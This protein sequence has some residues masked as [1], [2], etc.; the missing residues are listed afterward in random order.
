MTAGDPSSEDA[1]VKVAVRVRPVSKRETDLSTKCVVQMET[2]QT[3]LFH[4]AEEKHPKT[5]AFDH[6]FESSDPLSSKFANQEEVFN[7]VGT[8]VID[9]A[10]QGYNA[11]IFAY[12]QTG[13]GK[14]Y[15]MMGSADNP[16]I[17]PRLCNAIFERIDAE[18]SESTS[19][20]VEVSYME[21]Y[22]ERVRDLL[23]PKN[24]QKQI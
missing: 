12:G 24:H 9:N 2:D 3:F 4:P 7:K 21:I 23:D 17:I 18:T 6:C 8:G 13:S 14:S 22:N 16:G 1:K 10:F 19:F 15:T 11:C 20:K 5:F